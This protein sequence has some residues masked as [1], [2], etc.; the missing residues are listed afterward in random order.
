MLFKFPKNK[1]V[2]DC[3]TSERYAIEYAPID[4]AIK[5]IPNWWKNLPKSYLDTNEFT[6]SPTMKHCVGMVDYYKN[7]IAIPLWSDL[8]IKVNEDKSYKWQFSD[9]RTQAGFHSMEKQA[10]GF[11]SNF[12][13][14]KIISPWAF[15]TKE[16]IN[17]VWSHPTYNYEF[18]ED[19]VSLPAIVNYEHQNSTNINLMVSTK[20]PKIIN[21][22]QGQPMAVLTPMSDRK[23]EIIR[24]LV[25]EKEFDSI[26]SMQA[27]ISFLNKYKKIVKRK[28]QFS[29]CPY[30]NKII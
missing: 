8:S 26:L 2:L 24:H 7:S 16:M 25:S 18:S 29:G 1:I 28:E 22:S 27:R 4:F 6:Q 20:E 23:V 19:I 14:F 13:H 10:N 17:W 30:H 11:L 12:F 3:F 21:I 9:R 15:K 5:H